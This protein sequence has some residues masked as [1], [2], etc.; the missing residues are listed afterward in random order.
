MF[1]SISNGT[2]YMTT[3]LKVCSRVGNGSRWMP[4]KTDLVWGMKYAR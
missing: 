1:P 4:D 3:I 2:L